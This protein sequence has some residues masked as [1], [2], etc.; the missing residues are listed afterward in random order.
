MANFDFS[1]SSDIVLGIYSLARIGERISAF[2][3]QV[4]LITDPVLKPSGLIQKVQKALEE[5]DVSVFVFDDMVQN[6]N[7]DVIDRTL[8]LARGA[9]VD[10]I[11]GVG[12]MTICSIA[13]ATASLY[14]EER[15]VYDFFEGQEPKAPPLPLCQ[16][17]T[18]CRDPFLCM[19]VSPITDARNRNTKLLKL[20]DSLGSLIMFDPNVY[21]GIPKNSLNSMIFAGVSAA[22]EGYISTKS[23]FF[24]QTTL[25]RA[26]ELFL[27]TVNQQKQKMIG[28]SVEQVLAEATCLTALGLSSS[29]PG[30]G[31]ALSIATSSRY[32][33]SS[34]LIASILFPSV[35]ADAI[36]SNL[37]KVVD[38][39]RM[40][41]TELVDESDLLAKA[42][43]GVIEVRR[44][45]SVANLPMRLKDIELSIESLVPVAQDAASLSFISYLPRPLS[46][47]GIFELIKEAY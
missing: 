25:K 20:Q 30:L 45:L 43:A 15:S 7:S 35:L 44:Q 47:S 22:F 28:T 40:L 10:C 29:S 37:D 9:K 36:K 27:S 21:S 1:L 31:T 3:R 26:I 19:K 41:E 23:N 6:P 17:P 39:A 16:V 13:R 2:S 24:S 46:S 14:N 5:Y 34:S 8:K 11:I 4:M 38:V 12:G 32:D 42:E 18:T 33:I